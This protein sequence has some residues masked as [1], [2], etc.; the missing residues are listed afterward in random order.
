MI[1]LAAPVDEGLLNACGETPSLVCEAMWNLTHN[2]LVTRAAD[3]FV[4]KPVV[5]FVILLIT[6]I[7]NH[8][9]RK[10]VTKLIIRVANRDELAATALDKIGIGAPSALAVTHDP[11]ADQRQNTLTAVARA[12]VSGVVWSI[13][14]LMVL[15]VFNLNLA[16]LIAGAGIAGLAVGL[17]AQSLVKDCIAGFFIILEDQFGVGD[18]TDL[19]PATGTVEALTLRS[20]SLRGGDGT[21]WSIPN[22]AIVRVGNQSKV[23]SKA[24]LDVSIWY[25]ADVDEAVALMQ[26]VAAEVCALPEFE[27]VVLDPPTVLGVERLTADGVVLRVVVRTAP[28][29]QW[30]LMRVLRSALKTAFEASGLS[31]YRP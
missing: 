5:A 22:G 6:A 31:L 27:S 20:T 30:K 29:A 4:A 16:P 3:W 10:A 15:G 19:G 24:V 25:A 12:C 26:R 11:R 14:V 23:W 21:L 17:G 18:E 2:R 13:G 9:L 1:G 7:V 28:G 8:W